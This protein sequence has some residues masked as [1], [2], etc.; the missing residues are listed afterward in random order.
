MINNNGGHYL[1]SKSFSWQPPSRIWLYAMP[2]I[3]WGMT[4][5]LDTIL[6]LDD[7]LRSHDDVVRA[8]QEQ[9]QQ[10]EQAI[11]GTNSKLSLSY[12]FYNT[13]TEELSELNVNNVLRGVHARAFPKWQHGPIPCYPPS[14]EMPK[15]RGLLYLKLMKTGG[16]TTSGVNARIARNEA[17]RRINATFV[18]CAA[19]LE[20]SQANTMLGPHPRHRNESYLWATVRDPKRR[21]LSEFFHFLV[22]RNKTEPS[23]AALAAAPIDAHYLSW[24]STTRTR[25]PLQP[26]RDDHDPAAIINEILSDYDFI[27]VTERLEEST[28]ALAM[29]LHVPLADVLYLNAKQNGGYDDL[30]AYIAPS[31]STP[32]I[33]SFLQKSHFYQHRLHWEH[34]LHQ[35]VNRSLDLTIDVTLGRDVFETQLARFRHAQRVAQARCQQFNGGLSCSKNGTWSNKETTG[36]SDCL[37][38]DSGCGYHCLNQVADELDLW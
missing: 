26:P 17:Q 9:M 14:E 5:M 2:L 18:S 32:G 6:E 12:S 20:H 8:L 16:S 38:R 21:F 30:C 10:R 22:S 29:L 7:D 13:T 11:S 1:S 25:Q 15:T 28:V 35:V 27:G 24:L 3:L 23:D 33:E 31:F 19:L 37:F 34:V 36:G 4:C